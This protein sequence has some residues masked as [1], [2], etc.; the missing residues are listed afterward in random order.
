MTACS[1]NSFVESSRETKMYNGGQN[2][3]N[4]GTTTP[5]GGCALVLYNR[6]ASRVP[7]GLRSVE[8]FT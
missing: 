5:P 1:A 7:T 6:L 2:R 4:R 3:T 8:I